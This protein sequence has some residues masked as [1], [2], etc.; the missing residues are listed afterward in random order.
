MNKFKLSILFGALLLMVTNCADEDLGPIL[1]F[2]IAGKGA[3]VRLIS[4]TDKLIN[5]FDIEGS[6]Y[7]YSVEFVDLQQG[8]LVSEYVLELTYN[9]ADLSDGDQSTGPIE[10][11][12][13]SASEFEELASGFKGLTDISIPATE[14]ISAAG[15]TNDDVNPGDQFQVD[16][17][18]ILEDGSVFTAGNSSAAVRG[19]AFQGHFRFTLPAACPSSL[20]GIYSYVGSNYWCGADG[21]SGEVEII[22]Q[23]GGVYTFSDWAFGGY[24]ACYGGGAAGGGNLAFADVCNEVSFVG[25]TDSFGDAW[26][27]TSSVDGEEWTINWANTYGESG[28]A[29]IIKPGGWGFTIE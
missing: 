17:K 15:L 2:D 26:E 10:L 3:Y 21:I 11:R 29:V 6:E 9:D 19:S 23:G 1:T 4:E 18:V 12:S 8:D 16:G 22:A 25:F 5:L 27:F 14:V 20:E 7:V 28:S 24:V 13:F